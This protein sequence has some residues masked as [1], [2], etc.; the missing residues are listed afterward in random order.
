MI[1]HADSQIVTLF[2]SFA[3]IDAKLGVVITLLP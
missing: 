1:G 3:A 2:I